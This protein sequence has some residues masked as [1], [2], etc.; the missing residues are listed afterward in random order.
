MSETRSMPN[1]ATDSIRRFVVLPYKPLRGGAYKSSEHV[2]YRVHDRTGFLPD[3]VFKT[4]Q[5]RWEAKGDELAVARAEAEQHRRNLNWCEA[6][7][8]LFDPIA[9]RCG[10]CGVEP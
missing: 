9:E 1:P 5:Q 10:T 4:P 6:F 7:G 8:H 2:G 3:V